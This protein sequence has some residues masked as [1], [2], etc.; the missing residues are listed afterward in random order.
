ML[1]AIDDDQQ[2]LAM[3][4]KDTPEIFKIHKSEWFLP[5]KEFGGVHL[6]CRPKSQNCLENGIQ[7]TGFK[8]YLHKAIAFLKKE[9]KQLDK[10]LDEQLADRILESAKK[11]Y[12]YR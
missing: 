6:T 12:I 11:Y 4:Y 2:L 1:D 9:E 3:A 10:G 5:L 7:D 8:K